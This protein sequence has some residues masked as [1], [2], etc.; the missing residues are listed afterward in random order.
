MNIVDIK[1]SE[2]LDSRGI[3]TIE[4]IVTLEDGSIGSVIIPSGLSTGKKE[5]VELR[6][7]GK[8]YMGMGVLKA[9]NNVNG[10]IR[11]TLIGTNAGKQNI[12]DEK[13]IL[14]DGTE[15]KSK[16]GAN[17]I[18]S[19]SIATIKA[20]A[21]SKKQPLY[22]YLN[23]KKF[24]HHHP[25]P[26]IN[27]INGGLHA[28]NSIAIQESMIVPI[29][30]SNIKDAL[31]MSVETIYSLK[32]NLKSMN[33]N[34]NVG[35]E[36]GFAPNFNSSED[37]LSFIV[38]AIKDAGYMP[39]KDIMIA[40]DV[41]ASSIY[42]AKKYN[43]DDK[44]LSS[45]EL[46][47]YYSYICDKYPILSIEDGMA[48]DDYKGWE[49][50]IGKLGNRIKIIGDDLFATNPYTIKQKINLA[51]GIIIKYNQIGTIT[52]VFSAINIA[53]KAGYKIVI[54]HRSGETEDTTIAH[55][56]FGVGADYIKTGSVCRSERV[57]KY[58]ELMRIAEDIKQHAKL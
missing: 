6:D 33:Y 25:T 16:L 29:G 7:G 30:A 26:M 42:N 38:Q 10:P 57:A 43:L 53:K 39:G 4:T 17:A 48:E 18:L 12:I 19:V 55:I 24:L 15:N 20:F 37:T 22:Q 54:S 34:I 8:R 45:D 36:G 5:A 58:N 13:L 46:I 32:K 14:L 56:A 21:K 41:A 2:L 9:I 50:L 47:S 52:E 44:S 51:N 28:D 11:S 3:P 1:A 27:V 35:D 49:N 23:A 40:L 31:R